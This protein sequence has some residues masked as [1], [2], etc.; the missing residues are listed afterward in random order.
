MDVSVQAQVLNL[1]KA[2]QQKFNLAY[3]FISHDLDV[4]RWMS[5]RIAIMYGG[6]IVE[7][8]Q[9]E[10]IGN[11]PLHPYAEVLVNAFLCFGNGMHNIAKVMD[12][13]LDKFLAGCSFYPYC[14]KSNDFCKNR[15]ELKEIEKGHF[16][17]CWQV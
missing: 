6:R 16:V 15:P 9:M 8:G 13:E 5:N 3:L 12:M 17:A 10:N 1:L 4:V 7:I 2:V 11:N 14:P